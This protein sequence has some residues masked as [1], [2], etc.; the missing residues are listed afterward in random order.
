MALAETEFAMGRR[1]GYL[2]ALWPIVILHAAMLPV[3]VV[4]F[5]EALL[6]ASRAPKRRDDAATSPGAS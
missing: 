4:R 2:D 6:A 3:N 1:Y 5:R